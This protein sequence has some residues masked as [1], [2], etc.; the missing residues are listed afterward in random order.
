MHLVWRRYTILL[1]RTIINLTHAIRMTKPNFG[2]SHYFEVAEA[3]VVSRMLSEKENVL[4]E[5]QWIMVDKTTVVRQGL[6]VALDRIPVIR[7]GLSLSHNLNRFVHFQLYCGQADG[8]LIDSIPS[9]GALKEKANK[10]TA[11]TM[12]RTYIV[13]GKEA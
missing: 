1:R 3:A 6:T 2:G 11:F 7:Y 13:T 8:I 12:S 5:E 9:A 10:Y 4:L